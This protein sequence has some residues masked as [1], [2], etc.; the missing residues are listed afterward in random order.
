M[1]QV[2]VSIHVGHTS[3]TCTPDS[4]SSGPYGKTRTI[5]HANPFALQT[6][7]MSHQDSPPLGPNLPLSGGSSPE[8]AIPHTQFSLTPSLH[9]LPPINPSTSTPPPEQGSHKTTNSNSYRLALTPTCSM[10]KCARGHSLDLHT[11]NNYNMEEV[12]SH[13]PKTFLHILHLT[14]HFLLA[15][16]HAPQR[17]TTFYH[18]PCTT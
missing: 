1:A 6:L 16:T 15:P 17:A 3:P 7:H 5:S 10:G 13:T 14:I 18:F 2:P 11:N 8:L 12:T 9:P 4:H